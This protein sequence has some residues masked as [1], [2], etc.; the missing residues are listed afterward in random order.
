MIG[1]RVEEFCIYFYL[2]LLKIAQ[3]AT[4]RRSSDRQGLA[5]VHIRWREGAGPSRPEKRLV[6]VAAKNPGRRR[7][8]RLGRLGLDPVRS[9]L[10]SGQAI[11]PGSYF[12]ARVDLQVRCDLTHGL[13]CTQKPVTPSQ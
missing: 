1:E 12:R 6:V 7:L 2:L 4:R 9:K 5:A 8:C 13:Q 3:I 10:G 11:Q